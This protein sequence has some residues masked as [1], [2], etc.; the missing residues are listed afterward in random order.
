[1]SKLF[2]LQELL[3]A[4]G[5][6]L[7]GSANNFIEGFSIDSRTIP[8]NFC[9]IA[10]RGKNF[11]GHNFINQAIE[12]GAV[13]VIGEREIKAN[14]PVILVKDSYK[15]LVKIAKYNRKRIGKKAKIIGITGS[16]GKTSVKEIIAQL[17]ELLG[18]RV[19]Y[20]KGNYNNEIGLPLA[21][22]NMPLGAEYGVFE[23]GMRGFG[24]IE[25]LTKIARPDVA[26]ITTIAPVH[27]EFFNSVAEI[28]IAKAEIMKGL[29][30][31][32]VCF[33]PKDNEH[34][35]VLENEA[36]RLEVKNI[37]AFKEADGIEIDLPQ[38]FLVHKINL[39]IAIACLKYLKLNVNSVLQKLNSL[40]PEK[41]RGE[42]I[43]LKGGITVINDAYNASPVSVKFAL[44][45]LK[46]MAGLKVAV[47]GDMKE[48]GVQEIEY[49]LEI[50]AELKTID[51][52]I[53]HGEL[54]RQALKG[55]SS[56]NIILAQNLSDILPILEGFIN[57]KS[58]VNILFKG[59]NST[60]IHKVAEEF[61]GI[62]NFSPTKK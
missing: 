36:K 59:S 44:Q 24:Q 60:N 32:G 53:L 57:K 48:L 34:F 19:H 5:G 62:N 46:K 17:L 26:I 11:D 45:N 50:I 41:G 7:I 2:S 52:A 33:L 25:Y 27:L 15:A 4:S 39:I 3:K 31:N 38:N 21:I 16:V 28:A 58:A 20:T 40:K 54:Y 22:A 8:R 18:K 12:K 47:L 55:G 43:K 51:L 30:K 23:M 35:S 6:R 29:T 9:F 61:V 1:M 13:A 10:L 42:I 14:V 37:I 49:H 56:K